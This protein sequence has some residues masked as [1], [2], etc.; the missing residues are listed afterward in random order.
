MNY[1]CARQKPRD[2]VR[3]LIQYL[4]FIILYAIPV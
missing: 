1:L 2:C 4:E 3:W